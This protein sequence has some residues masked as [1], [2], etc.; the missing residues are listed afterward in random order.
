MKDGR[1]IYMHPEEDAPKPPKA[2]NKRFITRVMFPAA[3]ARSRMI[4]DGVYNELM[5]DKVIPGIKAR[6]PRPPGHT[7][8][9]QQDGAKPHTGGGDGGNSGKGEGH[10][11]P[12]NPACQL[13]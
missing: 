7:I 11:H 8:F 9:V 3:V 13:T 10:H 5:I 4:S 2:Q 6:M 12:E 1:G